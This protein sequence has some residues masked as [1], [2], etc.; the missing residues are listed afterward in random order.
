[1]NKE[2]TL[3]AKQHL[4]EAG[5]IAGAAATVA[6]V[7]RGDCVE[8]NFLI[9]ATT[10]CRERLWVV[11][12]A[13]NDGCLNGLVLN[14]PIFLNGDSADVV[15]GVPLQDVL[16]IMRMSESERSSY[17]ASTGERAVNWRID[18]RLVNIAGGVETRWFWRKL[19]RAGLVESPGGFLSRGDC[20]EDAAKHGYVN[21]DS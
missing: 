2:E 12:D 6:Q 4:L 14:G 7:R 11:V 13:I 1:M 19:G 10:G 20:E 17:L 21:G 8:V 9:D 18:T 16:S 3:K 5:L 15:K